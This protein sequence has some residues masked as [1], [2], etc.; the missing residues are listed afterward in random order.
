MD[1]RPRGRGG[2]GAGIDP[3]DR[4]IDVVLLGV[5]DGPVGADSV[6]GRAVR[7]VRI[8]IAVEDCPEEGVCFQSCFGGSNGARGGSRGVGAP[9]RGA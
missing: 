5:K 2:R 1:D 7:G 3:F 9:C 8:R 6:C 4:P